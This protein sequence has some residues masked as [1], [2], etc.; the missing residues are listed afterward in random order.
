MRR[1]TNIAR[2]ASN[3]EFEGGVVGLLLRQLVRLLLALALQALDLVFELLNPVMQ[4]ACRSQRRGQ[5]VVIVSTSS[6]WNLS[7]RWS[8]WN[9]MVALL[10][11][12]RASVN[13]VSLCFACSVAC[14]NARSPAKAEE[15][16][17]EVDGALTVMTRLACVLVGTLESFGRALAR[18]M[19]ADDCEG[20]IT[21]HNH[22]ELINNESISTTQRSRAAWHVPV[23]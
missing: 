12:R 11:C 6:G 20:E 16:A 10:F 8:M 14:A 15:V 7:F 18:S 19:C 23:L 3:G 17:E 1:S 4:S 13:S 2:E 21:N 5:D 22:M 9:V